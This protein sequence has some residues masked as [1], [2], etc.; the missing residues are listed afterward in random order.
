MKKITL[1]IASLSSGGAEHQLSVLANFLVEKDYDVTIVTFGESPDH[2]PL[3]DNIR[4]VRLGEGHPKWCKMI[5]VL[6]FFMKTKTDVAIGFGARCN[7]IMLLPLVFN[8]NKILKIS[9]ER[10]AWFGKYPWY[11]NLNLKILYTTTDYI[12]PNSYSQTEQILSVKPIYRSKICTITNYTDLSKYTVTPLPLNSTLKIGIFSRYEVQKNFHR[13]IEVLHELKNDGYDNFHVDWYGELH[14]SNPILQKYIDEGKMLIEKYNV[15]NLITLNDKTKNVAD[16]IPT[17]DMMCLPSL[18]EGFSNSLSEYIC[19]G[20][21]VLCS[22]VADNS[23]M[24][25]DGEN[26]FLFNPLSVESMVSALKK[27]FA[28]SDAERISMGTRSRQIA[29]DLFDKEKF[30]ESYIKLIE[31]K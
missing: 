25:N 12:V 2:Y 29:E 23:I 15:G 11:E 7:C 27:Y 21:P 9:S 24:V 3:N 13:F 1:F 14:Y 16:L 10:C 31:L 19:C 8:H 26:G 30:I 4:R 28:L 22:D 6:R 17:Y 20:R 5:S 18:V